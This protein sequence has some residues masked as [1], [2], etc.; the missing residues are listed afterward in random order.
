MIYIWNNFSSSSFNVDIGIG[1]GSALSPIL[2]VLYLFPI[3]YILEKRL[4]NLKILISILSFVDDS[5]FIAQNKSLNVS[6]SYLFCSYNI[7]SSLLKQFGLIIEYGKMEV[8]HFFRVHGFFNLSLLDLTILGGSILCPKETWQYLGFI[9]NRK[10]WHFDNISI[11]ML[12]KQYQPLRELIPNQK[13]LLY[14]VCILSIIL[15]GF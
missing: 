4:K 7:M 12:I 2:S 9:F 3:F 5:L 13:Q 6:N 8:F 10:S 11:F 1:Q 14:R 15:Y